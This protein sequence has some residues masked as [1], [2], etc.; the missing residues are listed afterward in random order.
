MGE[1]G[2]TVLRVMW[3]VAVLLPWILYG[4]LA[5]GTVYPMVGARK[6]AAMNRMWSRV[7]LRIFD[8]RMTVSG[9]PVTDRAVLYVAKH[10]SWIDIFVMNA[11]RPTAFI[12]KS[13]IRDW[14]IIGWLV[15]GA[16]TLFIERWQRRAIPIVAQAMQSRF[17]RNE[18]VG[19]YPEGTTSDGLGLLPFRASLFEP[20]HQIGVTIQPV[21]LVYGQ[22]GGRTGFP[23]FV[24]EQTL[25][26]NVIELLASRGLTVAAHYLPPLPALPDTPEGGVSARVMLAE[27]AYAAMHT[28]VTTGTA[29]QA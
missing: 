10:V 18:A 27:A 14:P 8:L 13:E 29:T 26:G 12:A 22:N 19:L 1:W 24:G 4:L 25:V 16:G 28:V 15:A 21:A 6:R 23:A 9:V 2:V 5:V 7:L 20:A 11:H 17:A 3:R